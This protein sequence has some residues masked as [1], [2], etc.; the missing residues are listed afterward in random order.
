MFTKYNSLTY[1]T[2]EQAMPAYTVVQNLQR[3]E[4]TTTTAVETNNQSKETFELSSPYDKIRLVRRYWSVPA[5]SE[6][7]FVMLFLHGSGEH[8]QR[9]RHV[10]KFFNN[11]QIP[12]VSYDSRGHGLS[13]GERG[14]IFH[15][16][17]LIE[18]LEYVIKHIRD[19]LHLKMP[20]VI[21]AHGTGCVNCLGHILRRKDR[22]LDC[23]GLILSTPSVCLKKRPTGIV[24]V[25]A[26]TFA[27]LSPHFR[28]PIAGNYTNKYTND[29]EVVEAYR[30]DPLVHDRWPARTISL[31][32]EVG[33]LL[34]T[35]V[36]QFP[37][38]LLIQHG[39]DDTVTPI[40][41]I[42]KWFDERIEGE[43]V[44]FKAWPNHIHELHNDL[45][46]MDDIFILDLSS[47]YP[48]NYTTLMSQQHL[49]G[50]LKIN[51]NSADEQFT[52]PIQFTNGHTLD[53]KMNFCS[54]HQVVSPIT[55]D[56]VS[57]PKQNWTENTIF[58]YTNRITYGSCQ[59]GL[60]PNDDKCVA[61]QYGP[62]PIQVVDCHL[63][64]GP[65][66][67]LVVLLV[68]GG[69]WSAK[70]NRSIENDVANDLLRFN[71]V[72]CNLDYRSVG[73][74]GGYPNTFYDVSNGTDLLRTIAKEHGFSSDRVIIVGHS[75]GGQLGGYLTGRF[76]LLPDQPGY[77]IN[78]LRPIAF[79]SQAGVNNMWDGC[80]QASETG[81]GAV[82]S[83]LGGTYETYPKRY[84]LSSM[85]ASSKFSIKVKYPSQFLPLI[86]PIQAITGSVDITVPISQTINF[87]EQ[88]KIAG[89]NCTQVIVDGE[90]HFVHLNASS[91]SWHKT[92]TFILSFIP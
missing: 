29:E 10:A 66:V 59:G 3:E 37:M 30:K 72:V 81:S 35:T 24:F 87:V 23:Q 33:L 31:Y 90:D 73:N 27:N 39:I 52:L 44:D 21:Y 14:Y 83:F 65:Y 46:T 78:P 51:N 86:V 26:R 89:D 16:N 41:T 9:Y 2:T 36:I 80:D 54:F 82:I 57:I 71:I 5:A 25:V 60:Y 32:L 74:K 11:Y 45:E 22:P 76:R 13:G 88:A 7:K 64:K 53:V 1:N 19:E 20:L 48:L 84:V 47:K 68:H 49:F 58:N 85:A 70:H 42:K 77:S 56:T 15:I 8:C 63:P 91:K 28:L 79:V 38:P 92:L 34:E 40:E 17:A 75:A 61:Y 55:I 43:D 6:S 12:C 62:D 18:D 67:P 69:Y 4:A 50:K